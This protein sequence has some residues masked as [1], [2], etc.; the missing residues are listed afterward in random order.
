MQAES[1]TAGGAQR[2]KLPA[3]PRAG[4]HS[5]F[6]K[7]HGKTAEVCIESQHQQHTGRGQSFQVI[8][9]RVDEPFAAP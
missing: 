6:A 4:V 1:V 5:P 8:F 9:L 2:R 7:L 3:N